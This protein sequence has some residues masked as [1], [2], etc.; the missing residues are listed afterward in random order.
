MSKRIKN[1]SNFPRISAKI[2]GH[3]HS[4]LGLQAV[5]FGITIIVIVAD[6]D[7]SKF[8]CSHKQI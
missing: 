1:L 3:G 8:G 5:V 4:I 7:C 6:H 2:V